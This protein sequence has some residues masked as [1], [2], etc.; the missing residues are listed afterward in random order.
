MKC[1]LYQHGGRDERDTFLRDALYRRTDSVLCNLNNLN[2][3]SHGK[4]SVVIAI[5]RSSLNRERASRRIP[6]RALREE[7][8][9]GLRVRFRPDAGAECAAS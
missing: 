4:Y 2:M 8:R 6:E 3:F 7:L 5:E 9:N 1:R